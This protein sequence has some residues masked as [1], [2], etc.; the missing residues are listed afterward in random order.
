MNKIETC[1]ITAAKIVT[2]AKKGTS[3]IK[4]L[5]EVGWANLEE[6]R[7]VNNLCVMHKMVH[8][9]EPEYLHE[10]LPDIIN[11]D[12]HYDLRN[13]NNLREFLCRTEKYKNSFIPKTIKEWNNLPE[14]FKNQ[15]NY[16]I[17][18]RQLTDKDLCNSLYHY[19]NRN[20]NI[21]HAQL[22]MNCSN[23]KNDLFKLHVADSPSCS[24]TNP[25]EDAT[26]YFLECPLYT[27][28]R[29]NLIADLS[30]ITEVDVDVILH[31]KEELPFENNIKIF[32]AVHEFIITSERFSI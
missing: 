1:Q 13:K 32:Q 28:Q 14:D 5:K 20:V 16:D 12:I 21:I 25:I 24:C 11:D 8:K 27:D 3:H 9:H 23:L 30:Q 10:L 18:K 7:R 6:R 26:H 4:L 31:G 15:P 29:V 22:R 19:G 17:F 2:G